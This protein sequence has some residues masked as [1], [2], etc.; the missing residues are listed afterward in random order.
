M[1]I[2][3]SRY[4]EYW[5]RWHMFLN[6]T[7]SHYRTFSLWH[8][9]KLWIRTAIYSVFMSSSVHVCFRVGVGDA[10]Y[11]NLWVWETFDWDKNIFF[12]FR[13]KNPQPNLDR[14]LSP[15]LV[16][17]KLQPFQ[18][19]CPGWGQ[20]ELKIR[21][22]LVDHWESDSLG[23]ISSSSLPHCCNTHVRCFINHQRYLVK[24]YLSSL[25]KMK[26]L[27]SQPSWP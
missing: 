15:T 19:H 20:H 7:I 22:Q 4:V 25:P 27:S 2:G 14:F 12:V 1:I 3:P 16:L 26:L 5:P 17:L 11:K 18:S 23:L 24:H 8:F 9:A 13:Q 10:L 6:W 21:S